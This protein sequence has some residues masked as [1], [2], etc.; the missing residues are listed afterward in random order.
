[1]ITTFCDVNIVI[2]IVDID[3]AV[4]IDIIAIPSNGRG[5]VNLEKLIAYDD[6][7]D[8]IDSQGCVLCEF[9]MEKLENE[10]KDKKTQV[11][12]ETI[13]KKLIKIYNYNYLS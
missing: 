5:I 8:S 3:E 4:K 12:I 6:A 13:K 11:I 9:V 1:M 2:F 7:Y 10:M